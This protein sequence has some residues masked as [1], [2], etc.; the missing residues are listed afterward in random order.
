MFTA[1]WLNVCYKLDRPQLSVTSAGFLKQPASCWT[2]A[3]QLLVSSQSAAQDNM[4]LI[5]FSPDLIQT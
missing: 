5:L 4:M 2:T 3:N 1:G